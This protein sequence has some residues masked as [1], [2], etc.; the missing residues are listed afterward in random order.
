M[1]L[2][3]SPLASRPRSWKTAGPL[4][5]ST[6]PTITAA[7]LRPGFAPPDHQPVFSVSAGTLMLSSG[8]R[9][10]L[11]IGGVD[12]YGRD[13]DPADRPARC[14]RTPGRQAHAR[15]VVARI[16]LLVAVFLVLPLLLL[17]RPDGDGGVGRRLDR[18][19]GRGRWTLLIP[20][21][22]LP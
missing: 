4:W 18:R 16:A 12:A 10:S 6:W 2:T 20:A 9:A 19:G 17:R 13:D 11:I 8:F 22:R 7:P 5:E 14:E 3:L 21:Q 1:T 15:L